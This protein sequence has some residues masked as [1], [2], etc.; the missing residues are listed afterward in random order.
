[1]SLA[2][3]NTARIQVRVDPVCVLLG[4]RL[5]QALIDALQF[6]PDGLLST[7]DAEASDNAAYSNTGFSVSLPYLGQQVL[8]RRRAAVV[9]LSIVFC[10]TEP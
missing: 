5:R 10:P 2:D 8:A 7:N 3:V 1:M 9:V 4:T 6:G